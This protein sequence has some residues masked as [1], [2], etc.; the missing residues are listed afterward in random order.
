MGARHEMW[1]RDKLTESVPVPLDLSGEEITEFVGEY[2][3]K[4]ENVKGTATH[5]AHWLAH[6]EGMR[7]V[8]G[9]TYRL[10]VCNAAALLKEENA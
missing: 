6:V 5:A 3:D 2:C 1:Y 4:V 9:A 8:R 10:A 7:P